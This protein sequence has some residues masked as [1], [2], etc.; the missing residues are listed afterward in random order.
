M[1]RT[2]KRPQ[3]DFTRGWRIAFL[4]L[5][6]VGV[7]LSAD[8]LR[9]HVNVHTNPDYH[10]Y[11]AMSEWVNCDSVAASDYS[12][13]LGLPLSLWG[14]WCYTTLGALAVWGLRRHGRGPTW[15]FGLVF[16]LGLCASGL[17]V[18]LFLVSHMVVKSVCIVCGGTYV[19]NF[20][21]ATTAFM[22][23][24]R[25]GTGPWR[26]LAEDLRS[27]S[28]RTSTVALF[29]AVT[30]AVP[31]AL[32]AGVPHYWRVE[33]PTGPGGLPVGVTREGHPWIGAEDPVLEIVEFS[34]YQC[35]HCRRGHDDVR[36]LIESHPGL[37]RLI[38]RQYPLDHNCNTAL[39]QPFHPFACDYARMSHCAQQ[40]G[41]FW[42]ANDYLFEHGRQHSPVAVGDLAAALDLDAD[43]MRACLRRDESRQAIQ[44]DLEAGWALQIRGTPTFVVHGRAYPGR[45]PREVIDGILGE[46]GTGPARGPASQLP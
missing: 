2:R 10:S 1:A 32:W 33:L 12:V 11:C 30:A 42:E 28:T 18:A 34:D 9:L 29:A 40:Q 14:L 27:I 7:C 21:L 31:V 46:S 24:R 43:E 16:W 6:T 15:P 19:V 17:G 41:R 13:F 35:P 38:H 39:Q 20:A 3:N 23:L 25:A 26:A 4:V 22:A 5:C 37:V 8:L 36:K 44:R 45:I